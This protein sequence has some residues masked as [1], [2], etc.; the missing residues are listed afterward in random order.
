MR[1]PRIQSPSQAGQKPPIDGIEVVR[2]AL[3]TP[4]A[5]D[6]RLVTG[7]TVRVDRDAHIIN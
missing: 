7:C 5:G 4:A 6:A 1:S 3:A 2:R